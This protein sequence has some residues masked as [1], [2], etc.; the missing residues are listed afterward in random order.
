MESGEARRKAIVKG[1]KDMAEAYERCKD[2]P[3]ALEIL[4]DDSPQDLWE[5]VSLAL[6]AHKLLLNNDKAG[7]GTRQ[8]TGLSHRETKNF[9]GM[10]AS[11]EKG[12]ISIG[13]LA[14]DY[15]KEICDSNGIQYDEGE[16]RAAIIDMFRTCQ[17]PSDIYNYIRNNRI[18]QAI[19]YVEQIEAQNGYYDS[20]ESRMLFEEEMHMTPEEWDAYD[21]YREEELQALDIHFRDFD[22]S[23]YYANIAERIEKEYGNGNKDIGRKSEGDAEG[24]GNQ[25]DVPVGNVVRRKGI[26]QEGISGEV[27]KGLGNAEKDMLRGSDDGEPVATETQSGDGGGDVVGSGDAPEGGMEVSIS[28][29]EAEAKDIKKDMQKEKILHISEK[30]SPSSEWSLTEAPNKSEGP[31]LVPTSDNISS[32]GKGSESFSEKQGLGDEYITEDGDVAG[33]AWGTDRV[34]QDNYGREIV[35]RDMYYNGEVIGVYYGKESGNVFKDGVEEYAISVPG[36]EMKED[37]MLPLYDA[38]G[39]DV[40]EGG[41][42]AA[43]K[44]DAGW[45]SFKTKEEAVDFYKRNKET[46]DKFKEA[47]DTKEMWTMAKKLMEDKSLVDYAN[48]VVYKNPGESSENSAE[49]GFELG[50][51]VC[52]GLLK[53]NPNLSTQELF[54][55]GDMFLQ[56]IL[57]VSNPARKGKRVIP[58]IVMPYYDAFK[59]LTETTERR[60]LEALKEKGYEPVGTGAFGPIFDQFKGDSQLATNVLLFLEDGEAIGALNHKDVGEI[61]LVWGKPGTGKSDGYGLSKLAKYHPEVIEHLQEIMNDM[62]VVMVS[63]NRINLESNTHKAA[64]RLTWDNNKKKWLLTAFE[65]KETPESIDKTTDTDDNLSDLRGDTALSQNSGASIGKDNTLSAEKQGNGENKSGGSVEDFVEIDEYVPQTWDENSRLEDVEA[66][67]K[68]LEDAFYYPWEA[69]GKKIFPEY[70]DFSADKKTLIEK[71]GGGDKVPKEEAD[72]LF[73]KYADYLAK[74]NAMRQ[75]IYSLREL[76]DKLEAKKSREQEEETARQKAQDQMTKYNGYL[77]GRG[78]LQASSIDRNLSKQKKIDGEVATVAEFIERWLADG[79]LQI[80]T[81]DYKPQIDRRKWNRMS[82]QEQAAW[83]ASHSKPKTEYLVNDY[84]LGKTAYDYARWLLSQKEKGK[85]AGKTQV[86]RIVEE[87]GGGEVKEQRVSYNSGERSAESGEEQRVSYNS[88]ERSAES[89]EEQALV[90]GLVGVMRKAGIVVHTDVEAGQKRLDSAEGADTKLMGSRVKNRKKDIGNKL[91]DKDLSQLQ[92]D[93]VDVFS[94]KSNNRPIS[95]EREDGNRRVIIRKGTENGGG[96]D[97]SLLKHYDTTRG[98]YTAEDILLIPDII[99]NG[100]ISFKQRGNTKLVE[101]KYTKDGVTYTV[102][103]EENKGR[104]DFADFYTNKKGSPNA[105]QTHSE[106]ARADS[107]ETL[108]SANLQNLFESKKFNNQKLYRDGE[109]GDMKFFRRGDGEV[110]GYTVGGEIYLDPRVATAETP[111]HEYGHLWAAFLRKVNPK[112]WGDVVKLMKE[113]TDIWEQVTRDYPELRSEDDIAEEVL[114]HYSG[115][116][117]AERL[118]AEMQKA[119]ESADKGMKKQTAIASMFEGVRRALS[120]FWR[121]VADLFHIRFTS[122]EDVADRMLA[123]MLNG[124][125]PNMSGERRAESGEAGKPRYQIIGEKGAEK[126][127]YDIEKE[128]AGVAEVKDSFERYRGRNPRARQLSLFGDDSKAQPEARQLSLFDDNEVDGSGRVIDP[129]RQ[130]EMD[131][132][133]EKVNSS[134]D[135]FTDE[136]ADYLRLLDEMEGSEAFMP[137]EAEDHI[138]HLRDKLVED[139]MEY[140]RSAG[141]SEAEARKRSWELVNQTMTDINIALLRKGKDGNIEKLPE[142][143]VKVKRMNEGEEAKEW[144]PEL[145]EGEFCYMERKFSED[146]SFVFSAPEHVESIDDVAYIFKQLERY[147]VEHSFVAL[148]KDGKVT[149]VHL[150]M[151]DATA[152]VVNLGAVRAALDTFDP[153]AVYF[154]HNHPSGLLTASSPDVDSLRKIREMVKGKAVCEALI[155]DTLSGKY[156]QF[157]MDGKSRILDM[158]KGYE[159]EV[160]VKVQ[161]HDKMEYAPDYTPDMKKQVNTADSVAKYISLLR[162]GVGDKIGVLVMDNQ[163]GV[164]ANLYL[165]LEED[166]RLFGDDIA[167]KAVRFGGKK[168]IVYSNNKQMLEVGKVLEDAIINRS[169]GSVRLL[170]VLSFDKDGGYEARSESVFE[171]EAEYGD[172]ASDGSMEYHNLIDEMFDQ[173]DFDKA[174]HA[175]DRYDIGKT[176]LWMR[177]IGML[178]ERFSLS[179]KN[180]KIHIGKDSDHNLSRSEWHDL[181]KAIQQPFLVTKYKGAK[182]RFRLYVNL[183]HEGSFVT[184]GVDVKRINQGRHQP[185][186]EVNSIKTIFAKGT[187]KVADDEIVVAYDENI[188]PEQEALLRGR[189]FREYPT[190]Q[191]LSAANIEKDFDNSKSGGQNNSVV[192][193]DQVRYRVVE[194]DEPI[195]KEFDK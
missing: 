102:L 28:S 32:D 109:A 84:D 81:R 176:P 189:N 114:M 64:V 133:A 27:Q 79:S 194:K 131:R 172:E 87:N 20:L 150:G 89:G 18:R 70:A 26:H 163:N 174:S 90:E 86:R 119:M 164:V 16:A 153:D 195:M 3:E 5:A 145:G 143:T 186:L 21:S 77:S 125:N 127:E 41:K 144:L 34:S 169:G 188:T 167:G 95:I 14:G 118:R 166:M 182:D 147:S 139:L 6:C 60:R 101:Y 13:R 123:D 185:I 130:A 78:N 107:D 83:E 44:L 22:F 63:E 171:A 12:G 76:R 19:S 151:G 170:D 8:E 157:G 94:G 35:H 116:R 48:G 184:V 73:A 82:G 39:K 66:R 36:L 40:R 156:A 69:L 58:T 103:T 46:I 128:R 120:R 80:S 75:E 43:Y 129:E 4:K 29:H 134:L 191:E 45:I 51:L 168:V 53:M 52:N 15:V 178:G 173:S 113:C 61:D 98:V 154:V 42:D 1:D 177:K 193:E 148:V 183:L 67:L 137:E 71:Y 54:K 33:L 72:A 9:F 192:E 180:I 85:L 146:K 142:D 181:P 11:R 2:V 140:H 138:M 165:P 122:A 47:S 74:N 62:R 10:F 111:I 93:V 57:S 136:Y 132:N 159:S 50:K 115:R 104:E 110:Y 162:V 68:L 91:S 24:R 100:S 49:T 7:K 31:D 30:L 17:S 158:P 65:K 59:E 25:E 160:E 56:E 112:G 152:A 141:M 97:Y 37:L 106:E 187:K 99:T 126:T 175:R 92:K 105:R 55:I 23:E 149:V 161:A 121:G 96:V 38:A 117:G 88:G 135:E 190:I 155:I 124:F 108:G 179:F